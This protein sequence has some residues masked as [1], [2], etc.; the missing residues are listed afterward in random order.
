MSDTVVMLL[1]CASCLSHCLLACLLSRIVSFGSGEERWSWEQE[2]LTCQEGRS[3]YV[4]FLEI[5]RH[6][7][8]EAVSSLQSG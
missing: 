5:S 3:Q 4:L 7:G 8:A 6:C 1:V 2:L